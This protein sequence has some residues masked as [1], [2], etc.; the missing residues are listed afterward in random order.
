MEIVMITANEARDIVESEQTIKKIL[1][2]ISTD[3]KNACCRGE[4][5]WLWMATYVDENIREKV[6]TH[7]QNENYSCVL[8]DDLK[9]LSMK[10]WYSIKW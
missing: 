10:W 5:C 9:L 3:I 2:G 8:Q 1:D 7:L 6:L 4:N